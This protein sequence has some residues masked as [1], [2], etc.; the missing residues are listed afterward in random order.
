MGVL[1]ESSRRVLD[2]RRSNLFLTKNGSIVRKTLETE[3]PP[4]AVTSRGRRDEFQP[5]SEA[6]V[7]RRVATSSPIS[8]GPVSN[9][10]RGMSL[11]LRASPSRSSLNRA[12]VQSRM[13]ADLSGPVGVSGFRDVSPSKTGA[14]TALT[15]ST[16]N[17]PRVS[18]DLTYEGSLRS[19][20]EDSKMAK[21]EEFDALLNSG[22]T[23][24][25]SLT[26]SRLKNFDVS[27]VY[28]KV[29]GFCHY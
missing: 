19:S 28:E 29:S 14:K 24:K 23:M 20:K 3:I 10:G 13:S 12:F 15:R 9:G 16:S 8:S 26:P 25:V 11:D 27:C 4:N 17:L 6:D 21:E 22:Q 1:Q 5:T 18:D 2:F 7:L